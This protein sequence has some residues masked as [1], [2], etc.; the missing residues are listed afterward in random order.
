MCAVL[1]CVLRGDRACFKAHGEGL[2][3]QPQVNAG[4]KRKETC[5]VN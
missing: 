3:L 1:G 2:E 4:A 5:S